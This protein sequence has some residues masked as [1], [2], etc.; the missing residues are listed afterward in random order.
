[1]RLARAEAIRRTPNRVLGTVYV[2]TRIRLTDCQLHID[3]DLEA[4]L[5]V[6]SG[7]GTS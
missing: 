6:S 7:S 5:S 4:A 2:E 1:M 3:V